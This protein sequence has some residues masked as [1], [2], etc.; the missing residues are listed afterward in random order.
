MRMT[1]AQR[2]IQ[3]YRDL[4]TLVLAPMQVTTVPHGRSTGLWGALALASTPSL[5]ERALPVTDTTLF[6]LSATMFDY[7]PA[8][9]IDL[10]LALDMDAAFS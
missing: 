8:L 4:E 5:V 1:S 7:D 2:D 9:A 6:G 3:D 10:D